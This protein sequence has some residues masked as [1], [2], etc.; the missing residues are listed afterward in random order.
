MPTYK[1]YTGHVE[2]DDA[3]GILYGEVLDLRDV[4]TFRGKSVDEIEQ[5]FRESID[6]SALDCSRVIILSTLAG[7]ASYYSIPDWSFTQGFLKSGYTMTSRY[8][9]HNSGV[10][11]TVKLWESSGRAGGLLIIIRNSGDTTLLFTLDAFEP[12]LVVPCS[13]PV[14]S[15][16]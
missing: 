2:Y 16:S 3:E 6:D 9:I 4:I 8:T 5:A 1:G 14:P 12:P 13:G 7:V 10:R 11:V 15:T